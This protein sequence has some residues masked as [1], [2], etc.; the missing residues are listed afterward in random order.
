MSLAVELKKLRERRAS[1]ADEAGK[2]L[3]AAKTEERDLSSDETQ[4]FDNIHEEISELENKMNRVDR[5]LTLERDVSSGSGRNM[6]NDLDGGERDDDGDELREEDYR[7]ALRNY[8][9]GERFEERAL[10]TSP[11][12]AGGYV[13]PTELRPNVLKALKAFGGVRQTRATVINTDSGA[14]L[15]FPTNDDTANVGAIV[16]ENTQIT[17]QDS[18]FGSKTVR[19]FK[20]T[21]KLIR[22]S[23]EL[24]QDNAINLEQFLGDML[25][26]RIGRAN[27]A[28]FT[29]GGGTSEPEG[30]AAAAAQAHQL[31]GATVGYTDLLEM[32]HSIDPAYR[33][34]AEWTLH[35][36]VLRKVKEET[37]A[38]GRP[39]WMPGVAT[40]EP[41]RIL[42]YP[43]VVNQDLND[44][45]ASA[46]PVLTF[47]DMSNFLIRDVSGVVVLRLVERYAEFGQI[48]WVILSRHDSR[49]LNAGTDPIKRMD[50]AV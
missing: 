44:M 14:D 30:Y 33:V 8:L 1:L 11:D 35:D 15:D 42:G 50:T 3:T 23:R 26:E 4:K 37:D 48:A 45:S 2:L 7:N 22:V 25:A 18:T 32:E 29:T 47:G 20:Y 12:T 6:R 43:Y 34:N 39:L 21:S 40:G 16:G 49:L 19:A 27:N 5:Q 9:I 31:A 13:V 36:T 41:D 46:S 17:E 24:L 28:H 10:A 38:D